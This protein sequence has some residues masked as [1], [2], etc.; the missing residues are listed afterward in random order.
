MYC[1]TPRPEVEKELQCSFPE[2][3]KCGVEER[4]GNGETSFIY[5]THPAKP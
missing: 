5:A 2:K 4:V 3:R 1:A